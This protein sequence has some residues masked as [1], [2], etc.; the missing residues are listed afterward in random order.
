MLT[1]LRRV[2]RRRYR[3]Y[4][5]HRIKSNT[6]SK[7]KVQRQDLRISSVCC[8]A[9]HYT[10]YDCYEQEK[11][12]HHQRLIIIVRH[13]KHWFQD[14]AKHYSQAS[15]SFAAGSAQAGHATYSLF[16]TLQAY[17]GLDT[18]ISQETC[19]TASI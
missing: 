16:R 2:Y 8:C 18:R 19:L 4:L 12:I 14:W 5:L 1:N 10:R 3:K 6:C 15:L 11:E 9:R 7:C 17:D 13:M